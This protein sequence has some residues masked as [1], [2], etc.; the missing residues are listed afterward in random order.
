MKKF[1]VLIAFLFTLAEHISAQNY[2]FKDGQSEYSIVVPAETS[3]TEQT[4][5]LE[6]Q[7]YIHQISGA[8]IPIVRLPKPSAKHIFIG[9]HDEIGKMVG[10]N[11]PDVDDE[12]F[13]YMTLDD[14]LFIY[15]G[16]NRGT[17]FGVFFF[18]EH[19]L[20][21]HWYAGD[22]TKIPRLN[23]FRLKAVKH[24]E[25][26]A[27]NYR[28]DYFYQAVKD[29]AWMAHNLLNSNHIFSS[30]QYGMLFSVRGIH[31]FGKLIPPS[32]YF[33]RHP[34]YFGVYKGQ[35]SAKTQLCL[36]NN[37]MC[38]ELI[39]NLKNEIRENPGY[40][41]YD[42]SQNDNRFPCECSRCNT[43][44]KKYGGQSGI[45]IWFVNK[46]ASEI[47]KTYPN[48]YVSTLAYQYTRQTPASSIKPADNV[49]IRLCDTECCQAH[50]LDECVENKKFVHDVAG[51]RNITN[52]IT[53][54]NYSTGFRHYLM[55]FPNFDV[56]SRNYQ[57]FSKSGVLGVLELG[58]WN[59]PWSEFSE[60]KQWLVA[61]L[62]WNPKLDT[63]SLSS[64]FINDYYGQAAPF[65]RDY[66]DLCRRQVT[67]DMHFTVGVEWDTKLYDDQ[68]F[69][70]ASALMNEAIAAGRDMETKKRVN[71]LAA[72]VYYLQLRRQ[73]S[74]AFANGTADK[75]RNILKVD[76]TLIGE[77]KGDVEKLLHD[78][79]YY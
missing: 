14:D 29:K 7:K 74:Q 78:L 57:F 49:I 62:L 60:L 71:R 69:A 43:L 46:V 40:W 30:S 64:L 31:S 8:M 24:T 58:S 37:M 61:K 56:I 18:L 4:A 17:M 77:Y 53:I 51:W 34:D 3:L 5:A 48:L 79:S 68:F 1:V 67:D 32:V 12:S 44:V 35:R 22:F 36:S 66:Y 10:V 76:S 63:D 50:P 25:A 28:L 73:T 70:D 16:S 2:L 47:K 19:E 59:A 26:P 21:V 11:R 55:P 65:V 39:K 38:R 9:Y 54:W 33:K 6:F 41:C 27:F 20:G 23:Q 52:N 13:T 72:Q 42:V 45:L 15:G 75:L